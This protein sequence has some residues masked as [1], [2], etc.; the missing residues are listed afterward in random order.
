VYL[1]AALSGFTQAAC[2]SAKA[3]QP[4]PPMEL[5]GPDVKAPESAESGKEAPTKGANAPATKPSGLMSQAE[6]ERFVLAIVNHDRRAQG[7]PEVAWDETAAK[8][9]RRHARDLT[10]AGATAHIGTD[11][12]PPEQRY[13]EAGGTDM[14]MENVGCIADAKHRELDESPRYSA[15]SLEKIEKAF[16]SEVPPA[17]GHKRNILTHRHTSLGVGLAKPRG[18]D[19][20]CMV[21]EFV[22]DYGEYAAI[23]KKAKKSDKIKIS[24]KVAS[25]ATIAGVGLSRVPLPRPMKAEDLN[26]TSGYAIPPPY[27][28]FFPKGYKTPIVLETNLAQNTFSIEAPL[29]N[30]RKPGLYG[31]SVWATFPGSNEL[32]MISLRTIEVQ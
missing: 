22:D 6:A 4:S 7:L 27:V 2:G 31:V 17:D 16:M 24:G 11:G 23:P 10:A 20:V 25:P 9:G 13:T 18:I 26:K 3:P 30:D 21:Q 32:V 8:A 19:A 28:N 1:A 29:N 12:S 14:V 5:A 15:A